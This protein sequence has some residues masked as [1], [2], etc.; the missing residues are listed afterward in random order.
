LK[1][2]ETNARY[3]TPAEFKRLCENIRT[4]GCLTSLP[5]C[6]FLDDSCTDIEILSG[7]HRSDAA[8]HVGLDQIEVILITTPL[9]EERKTA[10]QLA[11][12]AVS[13][14]DNPTVLADMYRSL[15]L[16]AKMFS[17]LTDERLSLDKLTISGLTAGVE[18]EELR[19]AFLPEDRVRFEA[20]LKRIGKN[21]AIVSTHAARYTDFDAVFDAILGVKETQNIVNSGLALRVLVDLAEQRLAQLATSDLADSGTLNDTTALPADAAPAA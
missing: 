3:M 16:D 5:L 2:R 13:G 18:Y 1:R 17:G 14:Q 8:I 9:D 12:N 19:I 10:I 21:K 6:C 7:H 20:A 11:H 4:D 15:G